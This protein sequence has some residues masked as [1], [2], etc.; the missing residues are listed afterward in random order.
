[1]KVRSVSSP[2]IRQLS[3]SD[4]AK[5]RSDECLLTMTSFPGVTDSVLV[6]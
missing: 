4:I 1:M 6:T 2:R 5:D 3:E